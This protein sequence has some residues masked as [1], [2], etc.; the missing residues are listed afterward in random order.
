MLF[1]RKKYIQLV[2]ILLLLILGFALMSGPAKHPANEF[3]PAIF[4]FR[5]IT[6]APMIILI[7]YAAIIYVIMRKPKASCSEEK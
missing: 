5:R 4:S 7:G 2:F 6:L 3:D 1:S